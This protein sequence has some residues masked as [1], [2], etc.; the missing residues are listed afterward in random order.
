M[1]SG[2]SIGASRF[3]D[4]KAGQRV[5]VACR[6]NPTYSDLFHG[7]DLVGATGTVVAP[8]ITVCGQVAVDIDP[9]FT[10]HNEGLAF[11]REEL[12][13]LNDGS[14]FKTCRYCGFKHPLQGGCETSVFDRVP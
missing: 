7:G 13:P 5:R 8:V 1:S 12:E 2:Q 11:A 6:I 3:T 14:P 9:Q 4:L 10:W